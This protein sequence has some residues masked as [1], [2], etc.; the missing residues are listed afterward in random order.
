MITLIS[1]LITLIKGK[2]NPCNHFYNQRN[3]FRL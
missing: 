1:K 3:H 2:L